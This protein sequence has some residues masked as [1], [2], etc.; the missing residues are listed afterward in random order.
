[1]VVGD[2]NPRLR[3]FV[4]TCPNMADLT[5]VTISRATTVMLI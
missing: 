5:E 4:G 2:N 3:E 1:M